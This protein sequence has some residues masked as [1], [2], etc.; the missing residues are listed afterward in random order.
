MKDEVQEIRRKIILHSLNVLLAA[1]A[2]TFMLSVYRSLSIDWQAT[3]T[4]HGGLLVVCITL[5]LFRHRISQVVIA[6]F[7]SLTFLLIGIAG[8]A[9]LGM[10]SGGLA[11]SITA[12]LCST[13]LIGRRVG[14]GVLVFVVLLTITFGY[15]HTSGRID[16]SHLFAMYNSSVSSWTLVVAIASVTSYGAIFIMSGLLDGLDRLVHD[17]KNKTDALA[18]ALE[19]IETTNKQLEEANKAKSVFLANMSHEIRTPMNGIIGMTELL[20]NAKLEP[21]HADYIQMIGSSA[22]NLLEIINSILDVSK[23]EAGKFELEHI[24]FSLSEAVQGA[25]RPLAVRAHE[26]EVELLCEIDADVPDQLHG[27]PVRLRQIVINLL[28]NAIK[29]TERGEVSV[30]IQVDSADAQGTTLLVLVRD[31]GIGM[32][33]EQQQDV[34]EA[35]SQADV[36]T[37]RRFGGTGLGLAICTHL[38]DMMGGSIGVESEEGVG[39]TF[40]F[41]ARFAHPTTVRKTETGGVELLRDVSVL[42][43]DDNLTN[44]R[45]LS[46]VLEN[47]HMKPTLV[48]SAAQGLEAIKRARLEGMQFALVLLDGMMP[49]MN[50]IDFLKELNESPEVVASTIMMLSSNDDSEFVQ[51]VRGQGVQTYLRK[52]ILRDDLLS[53]LLR[54]VSANT[55]GGSTSLSHAG[56]PATLE[57][58]RL[59]LSGKRILLVEDNAINRQVAMGLLAETECVCVTA[60]DG[61]EAVDRMRTE[62]FD[63][64][65]MD[66][67]MPVMGGIEATQHIR[68]LEEPQARHT[69]IVGLTANAM[70]GTREKC[71]AAGMDEYLSKPIKRA[72]LRAT[73]TQF[74]PVVETSPPLSAAPTADEDSLELSVLDE[75]ALDELHTL[76]TPGGFS[77]REV[78][79]LFI[80][81][82]ERFVGEMRELLSERQDEELQRSAH[83]FKANGR[84][85]GALRLAAVCQQIEDRAREGQIDGVDALIDEAEREAAH[86]CDLLKDH[87]YMQG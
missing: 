28:S 67:Q 66:M 26:K 69:P 57:I 2:P 20:K 72:S 41:T 56:E 46:E 43:V 74:F 36:S 70:E 31:T 39:S 55:S 83:T 1:M 76:E 65:L 11:F 17:L 15:L 23:I 78:M 52:P 51:S 18:R 58:E 44:R 4:V 29:F 85:L 12:V 6:S 53:A 7:I 59:D 54:T 60:A 40:H 19:T 34:F 71:I 9:T 3:T 27:D 62:P 33:K 87:R 42:V 63:L 48:D 10:M 21:L 14:V 61:Q 5:F 45:I 79:T 35:F 73:L 86:V 75:E 37:T 30:H 81:E 82:S 25:V 38:V 50:G 84:D 49:H 32:S 8:Y 47:W 24:D 22:D 80:S 13:A 64:V 77:L 68:S 16:P